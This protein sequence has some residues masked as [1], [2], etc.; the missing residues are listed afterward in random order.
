MQQKSAANTS[1]SGAAAVAA[2]A[3]QSTYSTPT[4]AAPTV[5]E[6]TLT[7]AAPGSAN[8]DGVQLQ[9]GEY[10]TYRKYSGPTSF[11]LSIFYATASD[12]CLII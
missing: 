6:Q 2:A 5:P 8:Y 4:T 7:Q 11:L 12:L 10:P 9:T 3:A 1:T